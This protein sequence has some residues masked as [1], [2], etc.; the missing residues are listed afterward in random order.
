MYFCIKNYLK[1]NHY[2]TAKHSLTI[3]GPKLMLLAQKLNKL[4]TWQIAC[5]GREREQQQHCTALV[6][7]FLDLA[8]AI[9]NGGYIKIKTK[10][11]RS[12]FS[13]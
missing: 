3:N 4:T 12:L 10:Y 5:A 8:I 1:S 2:H 9:C 6:F 7:L 11:T 13:L